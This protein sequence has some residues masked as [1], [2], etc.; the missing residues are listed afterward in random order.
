MIKNL[1][2]I[3]DMIGLNLINEKFN[4][5]IITGICIDSR[6][7]KQGNIF[8]PIKGETFNGH[9][10][11]NKAIENGCTASLWN[12]S[13]ANPPEDIGIILVDDTVKALQDLAVAYRDSLNMTVIGISGSNG[14]TSTKDI[15]AALL[16][17]KFKTQKTPGNYNNE[18]G[19]PLT[20]LSLD[21]DC[22]VAVV[23]MGLEKKGDILFLKDMVKPSHAILT[24]VG[25]AHLEN[26]NCVEEIANAKLEIVECIDDNGIF[27]YYGDD[28]LIKSEIQKIS[29]NKT[30][31][32]KKFGF[33]TSNDLY[34]KITRQDENGISFETHGEL[35]DVFSVDVL[36]RHQALNTISSILVAISFGLT[37]EDIKQ[38]LNKIQMTG[39]RNELIKIENCA[40]L[41]DS[42]KSNPQSVLAALDTFETLVAPKK[43]VVLGD[44]LGLG[45]AEAKLHHEIGTSLANYTVDELVTFGDLAE[46]IAIGA[47]GIVKS[48]ISFDNKDL[49]TSYISKYLNESCALLIKASRS[50]E[51]DKVVDALKEI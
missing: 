37:S 14:K 20:I 29:V 26:F 40:I 25:T 16:S 30:L 50:L 34:C 22:E 35:N 32:V 24:N 12:K 9:N 19:V 33:D 44:M 47:D 4:D 3:A 39:L 7:A 15:L 49:M 38:G 42:Y 6:E 28:R 51:F 5:T 11:I 45:E 2:T 48:I 41:N 13:E 43:I 23:E 46:N 10:Y 18:L 17:V 8:V 27:I 21:E 36:G 1:K 31:T